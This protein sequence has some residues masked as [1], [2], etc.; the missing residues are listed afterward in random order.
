[1]LK[2]ILKLEGAQSLTTEQ[3]KVINGG[4]KRCMANGGNY[5]LEYGIQCAE[6]ACQL[7]PFDL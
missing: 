2:N 4:R 3:K 5:C 7:I 1:M 6:K